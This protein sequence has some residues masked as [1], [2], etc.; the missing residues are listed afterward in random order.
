MKHKKLLL[1]VIVG[2]AV[3]LVGGSIAFATIPG[4]DGVIH[5]C[6]AKSG[7]GLRVIDASVTNCGKNETALDWNVQGPKGDK[8]DQGVKGDKGDQ[9]I[10][11]IQ[12]VQGNQG[13][14]GNQGPSGVSH[15]YQAGGGS[16]SLNANTPTT[17]L[18]LSL[19]AGK[20][21]LFG[22]LDGNSNGV[23]TNCTLNRGADELDHSGVGSNGNPYGMSIGLEGNVTIANPDTITINCTGEQASLSKLTAIA[24]DAIN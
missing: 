4:G 14:Q 5:G 3:C 21:V 16:V 2:L 24:V 11:G 12:G 19:P 10:Q 6:Y 23:A 7:G 17:I 15:V 1:A 22:K 8:G 18:S 13:I 9:G 20:F